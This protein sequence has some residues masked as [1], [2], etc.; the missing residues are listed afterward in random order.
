MASGSFFFQK[1]RNVID[2]NK[3]V[4]WLLFTRRV[5]GSTT[6]HSS[7]EHGPRLSN[8]RHLPSGQRTLPS[9]QFLAPKPNPNTRN[10]ESLTGTLSVSGSTTDDTSGSGGGRGSPDSAGMPTPRATPSATAT[11]TITSSGKYGGVGTDV[12]VVE[13]ND[14]NVNEGGANPGDPP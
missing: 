7:G 13:G 1:L 11:G 5:S 3:L 4:K 6:I 8:A 12:V 9:L 2:G 10:G 14:E